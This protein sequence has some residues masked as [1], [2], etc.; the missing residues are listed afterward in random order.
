MNETKS[1]TTDR[2]RHKTFDNEFLRVLRE[3]NDI[4]LD[5]LARRCDSSKSHMHELEK[6]KTEPSFSLAYKLSIALGCDMKLFA[7]TAR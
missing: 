4:T 1:Q 2:A 5:E 3:R 6:G 7:R